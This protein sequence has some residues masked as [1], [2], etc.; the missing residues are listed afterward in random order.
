MLEI[1]IMINKKAK[2]FLICVKH[3]II[4]INKN[5]RLRQIGHL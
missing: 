5:I 2:D 1:I 4:M 3:V